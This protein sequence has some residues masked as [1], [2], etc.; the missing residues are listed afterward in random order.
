MTQSRSTFEYHFFKKSIM[1]P[2]FYQTRVQTPDLQ[3]MTYTVYVTETPVDA[4]DH[5]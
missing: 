3:I 1:H 5:P 2:K 4:L